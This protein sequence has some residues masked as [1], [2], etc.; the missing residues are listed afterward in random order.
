M[1]NRPKQ[2]DTTAPFESSDPEFELPRPP[3]PIPH[4]LPSCSVNLLAGASGVGKSALLAGL[5]TRFR[6]Q[7]PIFGHA[8]AP[9]PKQAVICTD[10]SWYSTAEWF[11]R[12]GYP[13]IPFYSLQDDRKFRKA[14]L[15]KKQDRILVFSHCLEQLEPLPPG[16]IVFVDPA[17]MFLGGNLLDYDTC[18]VACSEMREIC[19]ALGITVIGAVHSSKQKADK[20]QRYV[21]L[22]DR[23]IGSSALLGFTDT[24][25]YLAS[26][27]EIGE[28]FYVFHWNPHLSVAE[29]FKLMKDAKGLLIPHGDEADPAPV[30]VME[31]TSFSNA[32]LPLIAESPALTLVSDLVEQVAALNIS[33]RTLFR[34][35][36][37]LIDF[38]QVIRVGYGKVCRP[39]TQ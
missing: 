14:R 30:T 32:L 5:A 24:Q 19:Q 31:N 38:K 28:A 16:S 2:T 22:Q 4:I 11:R 7:R 39:R 36:E 23:I 17:A 27:E 18:M 10:R 15:R 33:R 8:V 6:D 37:A 25:M 13:D 29:T 1:E 3:D 20:S 21:R 35:L 9:S 26:P 34:Q 12:A